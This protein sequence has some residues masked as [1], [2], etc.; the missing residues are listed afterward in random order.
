[1]R[2]LIAKKPED[3]VAEKTG[4]DKNVH[5]PV[6]KAEAAMRP[7]RQGRRASIM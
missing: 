3:V 7:K 6:Q 1:M 4:V 5:V 2:K